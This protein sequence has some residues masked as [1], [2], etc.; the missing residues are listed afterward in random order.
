MKAKWHK[1][2]IMMNISISE[3]GT[4]T[5][6]VM[7]ILSHFGNTLYT[8]SNYWKSKANLNHIIEVLMKFTLKKHNAK[9]L[10]HCR[11]PWGHGPLAMFYEKGKC[12]L[13]SV[14]YVFSLIKEDQKYVQL[15]SCRADFNE[16]NDTK[17][18]VSSFDWRHYYG[19][20]GWLI[21]IPCM[22]N[23]LC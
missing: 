4:L 6:T 10:N 2:Y 13:L 9:W 3:T 23:H 19:T 1:M 12:E 14:L 17:H 11:Q 18:I 21:I 8:H 7:H 15:D 22:V 5:F 16:W 20:Y